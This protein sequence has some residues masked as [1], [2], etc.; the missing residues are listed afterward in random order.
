M[1]EDYTQGRPGFLQREAAAR[2]RKRR[3]AE[4]IF[5]LPDQYPPIR[6]VL[7]GRDE[8]IWLLREFDVLEGRDPWEVYDRDGELIG[9]VR[10]CAPP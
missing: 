6:R 5:W 9:R 3:R 2:N 7:A 1:A 4:E 10:G 8:T